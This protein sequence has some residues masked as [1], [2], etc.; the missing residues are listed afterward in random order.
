M[1]RIAIAGF[2]HE[3][4][5]FSPITADF[6]AFRR[7]TSW[8]GLT[9]GRNVLA[10]TECM[11]LVI[12]GFARAASLA[13]HDIVP[14]LWANATPSGPVTDH[15]FDQ[16]MALKDGPL[17][18]VFLDLHGAMITESLVDGE[19]EILR[20]VKQRVGDATPVVATLDL[21]ANVSPEMVALCDALVA[22]RTYPHIDLAV[23]GGRAFSVMSRCLAEH[24]RVVHSYRQTD[25]LI[26]IQAQSTLLGKATRGERWAPRALAD[27]WIR[28]I[29][30][31]ALWACGL[32]IRF[33]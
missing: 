23:T 27:P 7:A 24:P 5:S 25:F 4:N 33:P 29:R 32:R 9:L 20:R 16:I 14:I 3:T 12:S 19:A 21:H 17:D 6:D 18:A 2:Q 28:T 15:A 11:K 10:S 30:H 31:A 22:C 13:G 26:P 1:A 8:P